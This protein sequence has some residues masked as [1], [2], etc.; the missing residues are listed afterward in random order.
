MRP[1]HYTPTIRNR[2][3]GYRF[4]FPAGGPSGALLWRGDTEGACIFWAATVVSTAQNSSAKPGCLPLPAPVLPSWPWARRRQPRLACWPEAPRRGWC[5]RTAPRPPRSAPGEEN[6]RR[7]QKSDRCWTKTGVQQNPTTIT[8][9]AKWYSYSTPVIAFW[10]I[11][12]K[13]T[14][15]FRP[16]KYLRARPAPRLATPRTP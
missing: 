10:R 13:Q 12:P 3:R 5:A 16:K 2:F 7:A 4:G 9:H 15:S 1:R 14:I 8:V 6:S 11:G